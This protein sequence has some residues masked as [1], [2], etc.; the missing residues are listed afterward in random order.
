MKRI[1]TLFLAVALIVCTFCSCNK[2]LRSA[3]FGEPLT[4]ANDDETENENNNEMV[5]T[6]SKEHIDYILNRN[7]FLPEMDQFYKLALPDYKHQFDTAITFRDLLNNTHFISETCHW[8]YILKESSTTLVSFTGTP[9]TAQN[10]QS[11]CIGFG[12]TSKSRVPVILLLKITESA[13]NTTYS[14]TTIQEKYGYETAR[15]ILVCD[16]VVSCFLA[17]TLLGTTNKDTQGFTPNE[18]IDTSITQPDIADVPITNDPTIVPTT[19]NEDYYKM[20][21][22][23]YD[24]RQYIEAS[25]CFKQAGDYADAKTLQLDCYYQ[26]GKNQLALGYVSDGTKYLSMCRGYKDTDE[27][28][29][30]F[31]YSQATTAYNNLIQNF[32]THI[33]TDILKY[34]EDTKEKLQLCEGYKDSSLMLSVLE[35]VYKSYTDIGYLSHW[36]ATLSEMSVSATS[37]NVIITKENFMGGPSGDLVLHTNVENKTFEATI[38]HI[39]ATSMRNYDEIKVIESLLILFTDIDKTGDLSAQ[40]KDKSFWV[41]TEEKETFLSTY[42][43]YSIVIEVTENDWGYIDCKISAKK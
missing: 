25:N 31:Y 15:S 14:P 17:L 9:K 32:S 2:V 21:K 36:E 35:C 37:S 30:S 10:N 26:H 12:W 42:G 20:G 3:F 33:H 16:S 4:L 11:L 43:G 28:L 27:I 23:Y 39:F 34:Y 6:V 1:I 29:L 38:T 5:Q 40:L 7:V 24:S 41:I 13:S 8:D 18:F 22:A 19:T